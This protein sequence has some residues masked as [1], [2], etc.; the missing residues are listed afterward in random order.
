VFWA[1]AYT[2]WVFRAEMTTVPDAS[3]SMNSYESSRSRRA[4][5]TRIRVRDSYVIEAVP[6]KEHVARRQI[7]FLGHLIDDSTGLGAA[8]CGEVPADHLG[9]DHPC[10]GPGRES[11]NSCSS[12]AYPLPGTKVLMI[13]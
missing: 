4:G 10:G 9:A 7:D 2:A 13:W 1:T 6:F 5:Y 3:G 8:E 12:L 11:R